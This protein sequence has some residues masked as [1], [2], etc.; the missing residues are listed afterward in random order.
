MSDHEDNH[1]IEQDQ[2]EE[3]QVMLG[4]AEPVDLEEHGPLLAEDFCSK[5]GGLPVGGFFFV[6]D[7]APCA[8]ISKD[9]AALHQDRELTCKETSPFLF[10]SSSGLTPNTFWIPR[11]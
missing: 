8:S 5:I 1:A 11:T 4:F 2:V 6:C 3:A 9:I 7:L 10:P